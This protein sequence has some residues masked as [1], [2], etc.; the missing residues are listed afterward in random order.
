MRRTACLPSQGE[1][2]PEAGG[3]LATTFSAVMA[4]TSRSSSQEHAAVCCPACFPFVFPMQCRPVQGK[5]G[6][7][8]LCGVSPYHQTTTQ[9]NIV[10]LE[11]KPFQIQEEGHIPGWNAAASCY[12]RPR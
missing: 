4:S 1:Q 3:L 11:R 5:D 10:H 7:G 6:A 2:V 9:V 8:P 12:T